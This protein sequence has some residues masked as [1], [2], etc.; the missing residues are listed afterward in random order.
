M[1]ISDILK[2]MVDRNASDIHFKVGSTPIM[3]INKD[4]VNWG[5]VKLK[6]ENTKDLA[7]NIMSP[8]QWQTFEYN[9]EIDFAYTLS[10]V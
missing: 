4:L 2:A 1:D 3:R 8:G 9:K 7:Q 6:A 10:G 5:D